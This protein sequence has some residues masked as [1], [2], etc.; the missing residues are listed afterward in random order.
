MPNYYKATPKA[1][2]DGIR[3][4]GLD[5]AKAG[6]PGGAT[7]GSIS[8]RKPT[9]YDFN[10]T[11]LGLYHQALDY[12]QDKFLNRDPIILRVTLP[13]NFADH[14]IKIKDRKSGGFTTKQLIPPQYIWVQTAKGDYFTNIGSNPTPYII[15]EDDQD[16]EDDW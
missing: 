6:Q 7:S 2:Y 14:M 12:A 15:T 13:V 16:I 8:V 10:Y 11:W 9:K 3:A 1:F 5:P 4:S